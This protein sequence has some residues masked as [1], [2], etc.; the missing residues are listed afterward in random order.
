MD[1]RQL[2]GKPGRRVSRLPRGV[3]THQSLRQM[4]AGLAVVIVILAS[5]SSQ[6]NHQTLDTGEWRSR[7]RASFLT[8]FSAHR[9]LL[10]ACAL[11]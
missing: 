7:A 9:E 2:V 10:V 6:N 11:A 1:S 8:H 5:S 3:T 4:G